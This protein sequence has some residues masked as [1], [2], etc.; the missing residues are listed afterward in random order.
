VSVV[1]LCLV[2]NA[3]VP[4]E[5]APAGTR[6]VQLP[7][8]GRYGQAASQLQGSVPSAQTPGAPLPLSLDDA[9]RRGLQY[10]LGTIALQNLIHQAEGIEK[11]QRANLLPQ[12][13]GGLTF[14]EQQIDLAALGFSSIHTASAASFP[15]V[16]GPSTTSISAPDSRSPCSISPA[17]TTTTPLRRT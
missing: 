14:S 15:T 12:I 16:V 8:S 1:L 17:A 11:S 10:N 4:P 13:S 2:A 5:A 9:V 3:Q 7:L 6:A